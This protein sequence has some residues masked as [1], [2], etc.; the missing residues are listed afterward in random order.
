MDPNL[1]GQWYKEDLGETL[2]IFDEHPLRMKM[3][4][5]SSGFYNVEPNC[6]YEKDGYLCFEINDEHYRMIYHVR[7][8]DN[9]LEGFYTQFGAKTPV[10]YV[11]ISNIPQDE[12]FRHLPTEV[13]VPT[14]EEPRINILK[15]Y[16]RY[17]TDAHDIPYTTE[18]QLG[19]EIPEILHRYHFSSCLQEI[20]PDSSALAFRMLDFV[21]DH[22]QHDGSVGLAH[23]RTIE[24]LI[25]F[26]EEH[27]GKTNCRGLAMLL[28]SLLRLVHIRAR[29]ITCMPFEDPFQD[30]HVV[31]DCELPSGKRILLDP[32]WRLYLLDQ[33]GEPVSLERLRTMLINGE[34]YR[35]NEAASYNG[36]GF[37]ADYYRNYM[38]KNTFRF[39]RGTFYADGHDESSRRR[40]ELIPA[41]YPTEAF[42]DSA[43]ADF[44]Y[45]PA[46]FWSM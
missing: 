43:Q 39:S 15:Q 42:R 14:T 36:T 33:N 34:S 10:R 24:G 3:S 44:V 27:N 20:P 16:A 18:Y 13:F 30:C 45:E 4:F 31:V 29:H 11:R 1:V 37:D 7:V 17:R 25:A 35:V 21:C 19:G 6:V 8:V 5:T 40:V 46:K 32:T 22:F 26:C 41:N 38:T 23:T 12:P 9:T 28:A 2:N